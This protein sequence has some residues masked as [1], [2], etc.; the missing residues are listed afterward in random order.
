MHRARPAV[1]AA[2]TEVIRIALPKLETVERHAKR[3]GSDLG[4]GGLMA[5]AIGMRADPQLDPAILAKMH[6]RH[7]VRLAA[8]GFEKAGITESTQPAPLP[9]ALPTRL[10]AFRRGNR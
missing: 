9:R 8:R 2:A 3:I 4:V 5:L 6:F 7:F 10:E 1:P